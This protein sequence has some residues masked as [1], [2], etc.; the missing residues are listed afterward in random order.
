M[1]EIDKKKCIGCGACIS[2]C[3]VGAILINNEGKA[4]VD[5]KKCINCGSCLGICPVEAIK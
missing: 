5:K 4:A 1:V 2:I 3:P